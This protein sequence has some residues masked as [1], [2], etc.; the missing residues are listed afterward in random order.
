MSSHKEEKL[1]RQHNVI[2][3]ARYDMS[4]LEK[5]ILYMTMDQIKESD[6][7]EQQYLVP[8]EVL[9]DKI[10]K[11]V[12]LDALLKASRNLVKRKYTV[13]L[14]NGDI[15]RF[16]LVSAASFREVENILRIKVITRRM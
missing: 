16:P 5:N 6:H 2:T 4:A 3:E 9:R 7:P 1:I 12:S 15:A 11:R 14:P 8:V 13:K 10:K